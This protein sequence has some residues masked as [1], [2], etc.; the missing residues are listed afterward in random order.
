MSVVRR[1]RARYGVAARGQRT[2]H[3]TTSGLARSRARAGLLLTLPALVV[4]F[5]LLLLPIGQAVYYSMTNWNGI[6]AQWVGPS[7][8]TGLFES[9]TFWRVMENNALL[10]IAIPIAVF[11]PLGIAAVLHEHVW[12]WRV[13]RSLIF[14]PTAIRQNT[15]K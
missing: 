6:T 15:P 10:A 9:A 3:R 14:L 5:V 4:V 1:A 11:I 13:F 8:Y 12:G 2:P 7:T